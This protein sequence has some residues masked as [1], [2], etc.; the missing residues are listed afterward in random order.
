MSPE[1]LRIHDLKLE[2]GEEW[3]DEAP[4]WRF[5]RLES[6]HARCGQPRAR[7]FLAGEVGAIAPRVKFLVRAGEPGPALLRYFYFDPNLLWGLLSLVE[8][9]VLLRG[10]LNSAVPVQF[11]PST[12]PITEQLAAVLGQHYALPSLV[13]RAELLRLAVSFLTEV[14]PEKHLLARAHNRARD[15]FE[16]IISRMPDI[17]LLYRTPEQLAGQ[18]GCTQR[19]FDRFFQRRFGVSPRKWQTDLRLLKATQ[20][21][22][23]TDSRITQISAESGCHDLR[24]FDALFKRRF[25]MSPS[26]W[27]QRS[28]EPDTTSF[29]TPA[30]GL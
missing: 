3:V 23:R 19:Q 7:V 27:R 1:H 29:R 9:D 25:G 6:G 8:R 4:C 5:A 16:E 24:L 12:H 17:E 20:L 2:S 11:L 21:L 18:C 15:R 13:E 30:V 26:A 14:T 10:G 22:R 28:S